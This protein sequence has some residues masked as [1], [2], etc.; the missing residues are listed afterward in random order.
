[1]ADPISWRVLSEGAGNDIVV[2]VDFD[3][4]GRPEA[5]YTELAKIIDPPLTIWETVPQQVS[6]EPGTPGEAFVSAWLAEVGASGRRVSAVIIR[7]LLR[8]QWLVR[9]CG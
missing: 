7:P 8:D 4:T 2:A 3:A 9:L 1:M 6:A 5:R